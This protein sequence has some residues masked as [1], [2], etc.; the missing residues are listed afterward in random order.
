MQ[1]DN[2]LYA[3]MQILLH[4]YKQI[5]ESYIYIYIYIYIQI[6]SRRG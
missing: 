5:R 2:I 1:A 6:P 4:M 3:C